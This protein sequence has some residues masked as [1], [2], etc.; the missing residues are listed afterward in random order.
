MNARQMGVTHRSFSL[1]INKPLLEFLDMHQ[2]TKLM[3][4]EY[5]NLDVLISSKELLQVMSF[6][7]HNYVNII[8]AS[9]SYPF[10]HC[11]IS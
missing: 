9:R 1:L 6:H 7:G 2:L 5:G 3:L 10:H 11:T 8:L 4:L